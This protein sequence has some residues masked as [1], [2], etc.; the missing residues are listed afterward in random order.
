MQGHKHL[1]ALSKSKSGTNV[2][3]YKFF[4][5]R[6]FVSDDK[7]VLELIKGG[8]EAFKTRVATRIYK[9]HKE[10]LK[11]NLC[12]NCGKIARTPKAKQ[13]QFCFA[14]WHENVE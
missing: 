2:G 5:E 7:E 3:M 8:F 9:D 10:N 11:L 4:Q 12:P 6:G 1:H 13:C 14:N